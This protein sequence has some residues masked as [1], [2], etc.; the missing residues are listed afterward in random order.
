M[1]ESLRRS[2][3]SGTRLDSTDHP[4]H[5]RQVLKESSLS[6]SSGGLSYTAL[7]T[8]ASV[9]DMYPRIALTCAGFVKIWRC[10]TLAQY[11]GMNG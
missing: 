10:H 11:V 5:R 3:R 7:N 1:T 2:G 9:A 6:R 4:Q 8:H